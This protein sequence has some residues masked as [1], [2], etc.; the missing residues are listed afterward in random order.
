MCQN[1]QG[2][3]SLKQP[4]VPGLLGRCHLTTAQVLR[5]LAAGLAHLIQGRSASSIPG[6]KAALLLAWIPTEGSDGRR[7]VAGGLGSGSR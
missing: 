1:G 3:A 2:D 4:L 5:Q 6:Y 7:R